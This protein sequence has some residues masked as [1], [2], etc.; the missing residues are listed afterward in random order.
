MPGKFLNVYG[1]QEDLW[2]AYP[3]HKQ[4]NVADEFADLDLEGDAAQPSTPAFFN[5]VS[6]LS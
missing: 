2:K 5:D 6:L 4:E 3:L 1:L